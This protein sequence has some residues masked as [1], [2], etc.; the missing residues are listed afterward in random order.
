MEDP[1]NEVMQEEVVQDWEV[2]HSDN[3]ILRKDLSD[4]R[5]EIG[6]LSEKLAR[7]MKKASSYRDALIN[8][9]KEIGG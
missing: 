6:E 7:E 4:A 1:N 3:L 2:L 9:C 5:K 8:I